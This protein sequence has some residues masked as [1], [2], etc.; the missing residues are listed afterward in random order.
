[1]IDTDVLIW[2]LRGKTKARDAINENLP[3]SIS[4]ITYMELVQGMRNKT[5]LR[6]FLK[7]LK[8]W[9]VSIRHLD[10]NISSR[11]MFLVEDYF[12]SHSLE[13][14]DALIAATTVELKEILLTGN[15]KHYSYISGVETRAFHL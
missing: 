15:V 9:H 7:Y 3:F 4:V 13:L 6:I 14:A 12:L 2:F 8:E 11:A 10:E 1:M 5:E